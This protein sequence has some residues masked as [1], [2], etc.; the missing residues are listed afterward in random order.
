MLL[1]TGKGGVGKTSVAAAT[2][3]HAAMD[4]R[5]VLL[6]S[7]DA[8]H[9]LAD[10]LGTELGDT[11]RPVAV[12]GRDPG[13]LWV[14][15]VDTQA[16]LE[17]RWDRVRDYLTSVL[18]WG[19]IGELVAEE[20]VTFPGL[21]ELFALLDLGER[22]GAGYDLVVVDCAPTA[23]TL[24][25]LALPDALRWYADRG[26]GPHRRAARALAS[27]LARPIG[28]S[29]AS[30]PVPDETVVDTVDGVRDQLASVHALLTDTA[31]SS[32]RLVSTP[33]RLALAETSRTLTTLSLFGYGV[34][35]VVV[36][37]LLPDAVTDPYLLGWKARHAASLDET[38]RSVAPVPVLTAPLLA[39]EPIGTAALGELAE[40][41]YADTGGA[42]GV[43][44]D[45]PP[46]SVD[47][48]GEVPRLRLRLPGVTR[49]EVELHH[50]G[51]ELLVKV[52]GVRRNV[53]LPAALCRR[54]VVGAAVADGT[55]TVRFA[56]LPSTAAG[57]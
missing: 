32:V 16:R 55:L 21:D 4:G 49:D 57:A 29:G 31:R 39:D 23:A 38:R 40:Q 8:A 1:F 7:T 28:P 46:V 10:A 2:A 44:H 51:R 52:A 50:H 42:T 13:P 43:L 20:L 37:R 18:A 56:G 5:R 54:E 15:Q 45:G 26:A 53:P 41:L 14:Q 9:S 33:E 24:K 47:I 35:A 22:L 6:S 19:G 3:V 34:D 25:L 48:H 12:P 27:S 36:N 30:F 11:P 17:A